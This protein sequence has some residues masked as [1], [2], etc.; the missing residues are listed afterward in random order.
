MRVKVRR[1]RR[2]TPGGEGGCG[3]LATAALLIAV[4]VG[5]AL[6]V[7]TGH[8]ALGEES[9]RQIDA[10]VRVAAQRLEDGV[11]QLALRARDADGDW[12][13]PVTPRAHRF[14]PA[15]VRVG[16][17]LVSSSL[18][19]DVDETRHGRLLRSELFEP[20]STA[21]VSLVTGLDEWAG[22]A[23]Y[24]AFHD[25]A[26][27]L[28]TR[29]S[30]YSAAAGAPDG[31]LRT[32][33]TCQ[34]GE[35]SVSIGGLPEDL[36]DGS[37]SQQVGM[38]W[39]VDDGARLS[40]RRSVES[41]ATG[42]DLVQPA[43]SK[44][45]EALLGYG[46]RLA[47]TVGTTPALT[48]SIDLER[49][50]ALPVYN[51]LRYC[52]PEVGPSGRTELRI[53]AQVRA[54]QRIEF[55]VQQRTADG[56]SDN[57]LSRARIIPAFGEATNWLSSTPVSVNV[58]LEP[59]M[60]ISL[61]EPL[62]R[63]DAEPIVPVIRS[64]PY[65]ASLSYEV[66]QRD[67]E[68]YWPTRLNSV[69]TVSSGRGLRLQVGCF[70]DELQVL[71]SGAPSDLTGD[72]LLGFDDRA[73]SASWSAD[74][75]DGASTWRPTDAERTIE[76]LRQAK[77]LS[78][79]SGRGE[80]API[81]FDLG[82]LFTTP[83]Q[84]NIDHCGNYGEPDWRPV[85]DAQYVERES[86]SYYRV[87]YR[88]WNGFRR[89]SHVKTVAIDSASAAA[90]SPFTLLMVCN[91][92]TLTFLIE[93]LPDVGNP[94]SI[95]LTLDNGEQLQEHVTVF[96]NQDG[97]A[98]AA[99]VPNLA[100][101]TRGATLEFELGSDQVVRGTF[102]LAELFG[103]PIQTN[104][105]NCT[106]DYWTSMS[107]YVPLVAPN[108]RQSRSLTYEAYHDENS[109]V[110]TGVWSTAAGV[111]E[112]DGAIEMQ[113]TCYLST[114]LQIL[115]EVPLELESEHVPVTVTVDG[116]SLG[117]SPWHVQRIGTLS[118]LRPPSP[119]LM[120]AQFR[121]SSFALIE[122]AALTSVPITFEMRGMFDT[123]VQA[124]L[125]EC[126]YYKPGE[127]R[128]LPL[129]L[130]AF[131]ADN[132][133]LTL[134][135]WQRLPGDP[136]IVATTM[137]EHH[138]RDDRVFIGLAIGCGAQGAALSLFGERATTIVSDRV[139]V[140][141]RTDG[142]AVQ[143]AIWNVL[144]GRNTTAISPD[145]AREV[146][147][148]W[149]NATDLEITLLDANPSSHHFSLGTIFD[150][151][152]VDSFDECLAVPIPP[153]S[154]PATGIPLSFDANLTFAADALYGS[155]WTSS[156]V[157]LL[158]RRDTQAPDIERD[159]RSTLGISCAI[160]GLSVGIAGLDAM[161]PAFVD[162]SNVEVTWD[163][164]GRTRTEIWDVW[165][166]FYQ[167][168]I[169]PPD[170][171]EFYRALKGAATLTIRVASDP[172]ITKTYELERHGFWDTPVQPN[173]DACSAGDAPL[174]DERPPL[175]LEL[176]NNAVSPTVAWS[177]LHPALESETGG[178]AFESES[179]QALDSW[180]DPEDPG[181]EGGP[182]PR[183]L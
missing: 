7:T 175:A 179:L 34:G 41:A 176:S 144:L 107:T 47:L 121:D 4:L 156:F 10:D 180:I 125:D 170:D 109:T 146:I 68:G 177:Y 63:Q 65:T 50:R 3:G 89:D 134:R 136:M 8:P 58:E 97:T 96:A 94:T 101:L 139:R 141:W 111:P 91:S 12:T 20:S 38:T 114:V 57:I 80:S 76:R 131:G 171:L 127:V 84:A 25:D 53:R 87:L 98:T 46:T 112:V 64:A 143:Q 142:G 173:L 135:F 17:W 159:R 55:A 152:V 48:T 124:N 79:S 18:V 163:I 145:R 77:H 21:D 62:I 40:E 29:V 105:D 92:Q 31:E 75:S 14:D 122:I 123:P 138:I 169:S 1:R 151:P 59:A 162:G 42:F 60:E 160:D 103:T 95:L 157:N 49:I 129:P 13:A 32:T 83:I 81:S 51:N 153:Q 26:G 154:L 88:E 85:T 116:R 43:G 67:L 174:G 161:Q 132:D 74:T 137:L 44:L 167:Y 150:N 155:A 90:G 11:V 35:T 183:P 113:A 140:A 164:D 66:D 165:T 45:S 30:I 117:T 52:D 70:G 102:S 5:G 19:L 178:Y 23:H 126:G 158:E 147:A 106:R 148:S 166:A 24:S 104:F 33:I 120:M 182:E 110:T 61:P 118:L 2:S 108:E 168:D 93:R 39:S 6:S 56:W 27:D 128:T 9:V 71:L 86:G 82:Y 133:S 115:I 78:V 22:D 36:G 149:R 73:V 99:F 72:L 100:E 54:D 181:I 28:R 130:N 69:V 119:R 172:V 15:S 16:R 37:A